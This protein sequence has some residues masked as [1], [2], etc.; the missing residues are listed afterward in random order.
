MSENEPTLFGHALQDEIRAASQSYEKRKRVVV[1]HFITLCDNKFDLEDLHE[2][3]EEVKAGNIAVEPR[4]GDILVKLKVLTTR[5]NRNS[6]PAAE[7]ENFDLL[8]Q[9]V[10][11]LLAQTPS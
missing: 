1:D 2:T 7:G 4:L 10:K 8:K 5:G 11:S 6:H 3:L 9:I